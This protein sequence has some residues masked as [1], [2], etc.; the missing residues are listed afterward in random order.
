[1][2]EPVDQFGVP[3]GAGGAEGGADGVPE[4]RGFGRGEDAQV[5]DAERRE[6]V[7]LAGEAGAIA[8]RGG[9]AKPGAVPEIGAG[10]A[11]GFA[12]EG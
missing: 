12:R 9:G 11:I 4:R 8:V 2:I 3:G 6:R 5:G 1:M 10:E 7:E